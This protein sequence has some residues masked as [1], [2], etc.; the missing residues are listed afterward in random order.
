MILFGIVIV[1]AQII[2]IAIN[3]STHL[4]TYQ[5]TYLPTLY[6]I[7]AVIISTA[8]EVVIDAITNGLIRAL[9]QRWF[10]PFFNR[11]KVSKKEQRFYEKL[12]IRKWKDKVPDLGFLTKFNKNKVQD[13]TN[14]KYI[15]RYLLEAAYGRVGHLVSL[16]T[17]FSVIF[18][19]PLKFAIN[20]GIPI[21]IVNFVLNLMTYMV[22]RY[23]FPKLLTLHKRNSK[24][25]SLAINENKPSQ[26]SKPL[27]DDTELA[28]SFNQPKPS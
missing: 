7:G 26:K 12:G 21:A 8:A 19:Y 14:N 28:D 2:I 16:F 20:F 15:E 27:L 23:N 4:P 22:L 11:F 1:V 6:I 17:G 9:P 13:P 24:R 10:N 25:E 3:L 5:P 18:I